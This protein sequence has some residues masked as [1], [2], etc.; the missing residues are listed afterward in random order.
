MDSPQQGIVHVIGPQLGITLPGSTVV[1]GD[2]HTSTHGAFGAFALGIGT[3]EVEHVLATQTLWAEKPRTYRIAMNGRTRRGTTPK[4]L[5]LYMIRQ[6]GTSGGAG[7]VFEYAGDAICDM[8]ME[9]R[10]TICNMSIEGG[11]RA[12]MISPDDTTYEYLRDRPYTPYDFEK[13]VDIWQDT[14]HTDSNAK[15]AKSFTINADEISPQISWGTN[16]GMTC[17]ITDSVPDPVE[18]SNGNDDLER[19]GAPRTA[20]HEFGAGH[21]NDRHKDRQGLYRIVHKRQ[22]A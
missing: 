19:G 21:P 20:I 14:L 4:D 12:G 15:F 2:S 11:A 1:C 17:D 22:A 10:M 5:I 13:L 7:H 3:S 9:Q 16:P 8:N 6:L 18:Y